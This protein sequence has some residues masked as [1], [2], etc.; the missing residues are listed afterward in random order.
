VKERGRKEE[1]R[2]RG[3]EEERK[4]RRERGGEEEGKPSPYSNLMPITCDDVG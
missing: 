3:E 4:R 1:E 2:R